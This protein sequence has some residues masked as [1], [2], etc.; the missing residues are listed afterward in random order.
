MPS[1]G[2]FQKSGAVTWTP[3]GRAPLSRTP[4]KRDPQFME[5][6]RVIR[7]VASLGNPDRPRSMPEMFHQSV[8]MACR[9][10]LC[11]SVHGRPSWSHVAHA[12]CWGFALEATLV[13][14]GLM[15]DMP[16]CRRMVA[17]GRSSPGESLFRAPCSVG[18]CRR[19]SR[20]SRLLPGD[21]RLRQA[22]PVENPE[23]KLNH[24]RLFTSPA[25]LKDQ[26]KHKLGAICH[27]LLE[28]LI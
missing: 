3:G 16:G 17:N 5:A 2:P 28:A 9:G 6:A 14:S 21:Q 11:R 1:H 10:L 8:Y 18:S 23:T 25:S 4:T 15:Y 13:A 19:N 20:S 24:Q 7:P 27:I 22:L 12:G 26:M